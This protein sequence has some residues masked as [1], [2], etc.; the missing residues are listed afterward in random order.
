MNRLL[1]G[2]VALALLFGCTGVPQEKYDS[3]KSQCDSE[4]IDLNAR[5]LSGDSRANELA[6]KISE[7]NS[8]KQSM[9]AAIR[10]KDAE[11]A[12]L[13]NDSGILASARAKAG[14]IAQYNLVT[15]YYLDAYGPGKIPNSVRLNRID[16]QA[17]SLNDAALYASWK[18]VRNCSGIVDCENAKSAFTKAIDSRI[19]GI[20]SEIADIVK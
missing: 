16:A 11:M 15:A 1:M 7:C 19:S 8:Q 14:R 9:D 6:A 3:L 10:A 12:L 17:A 20:E 4:K 2:I 5:L 18:A 13:R